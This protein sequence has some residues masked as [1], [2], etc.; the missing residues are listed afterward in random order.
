MFE[1][2]P[3]LKVITEKLYGST[4]YYV[5]DFYNNPDEVCDYLFSKE[6]PLWKVEETPS[7]NGKYFQDRRVELYNQH[8]FKV[9]RLL[10][11]WCGQMSAVNEVLGNMTKFI[12]DP[13]N[14]YDKCVWWPH[15]D[16]GY[17]GLVYF[18]KDDENCGTNLYHPSV[19]RTK[20]WDDHF[21]VPEH[22]LPWRPKQKY[23][24]IKTIKSEYNMLALFDGYKFPHGA[25][26]STDTYFRNFKYRCNQVFFFDRDRPVKKVTHHPWWKVWGGV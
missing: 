20:E 6:P 10:S 13:F 3:D 19:M 17:N 24:I 4:I 5:K 26:F 8:I 2:N 18:N 21:S 1:L 12:D 15:L 16:V 25:N 23:R 9:T 7:V 11:S 14:K 22:Y